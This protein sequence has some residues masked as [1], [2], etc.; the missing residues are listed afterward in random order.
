MANSK[1]STRTSKGD[2]PH[3]IFWMGTRQFVS[4]VIVQLRPENH[5]KDK[6]SYR[7]APTPVYFEK[8]LVYALP[9]GF[10]VM[11]KSLFILTLIRGKTWKLQQP[12]KKIPLKILMF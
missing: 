8:E 3:K 5:P 12:K 1:Y 6:K 9:G 2:I 4:P 11:D 7:D 10:G